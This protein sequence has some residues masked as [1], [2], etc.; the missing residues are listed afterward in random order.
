MGVGGVR[1]LKNSGMCLVYTVHQQF[2]LLHLATLLGAPFANAYPYSLCLE[3]RHGWTIPEFTETA[4]SLNLKTMLLLIEP[5]M[6]MVQVSDQMTSESSMGPVVTSTPLRL[7][8]QYSPR[9][10]I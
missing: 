2:L 5:K 8:L 7:R 9:K 6:V 4:T 10:I 3:P 1:A